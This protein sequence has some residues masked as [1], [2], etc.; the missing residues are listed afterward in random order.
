MHS[1]TEDA[2]SATGATILT[3]RT[4][5][6]SRCTSQR[7]NSP[8]SR[9]PLRRKKMKK[10]C[11]ASSN[12]R[13]SKNH[14]PSATISESRNFLHHKVLSFFLRRRA[15]YFNGC[16]LCGSLLERATCCCLLNLVVFGTKQESRKHRSA[17]TSVRSSF[18]LSSACFSLRLPGE[19]GA[20]LNPSG[21]GMRPCQL[22]PRPSQTTTT[23]R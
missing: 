19:A 2:A 20:P 3:R 6:T 4:R 15:S 1:P 10:M 17:T 5:R 22:L 9:T 16:V 7:S 11:T 13:A 12:S 21:L 8:T 23:P 14:T 18:G